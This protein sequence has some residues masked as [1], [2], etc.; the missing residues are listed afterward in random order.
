MAVRITSSSL[1]AGAFVAHNLQ[2]GRLPVGVCAHFDGPEWL[3][4]SNPAEQCLDVS[5][6]A[7]GVT[8]APVYGE[9]N[10][11]TN[12]LLIFNEYKRIHNTYHRVAHNSGVAVGAYGYGFYA[13]KEAESS[14]SAIATTDMP[15]GATANTALIAALYPL[16]NEIMQK[17][18]Q[19][20]RINKVYSTG[21]GASYH[22]AADSFNAFGT[23][24]VLTGASTG[25]QLA[26]RVNLIVEKA[27]DH[28]L[29]ATGGVHS[30][31]DSA[32]A[33]TLAA[34]TPVQSA[35]DF[36]AMLT[37]LTTTKAQ[38]NAHIADGSIHNAADSDNTI[39]T[40]NPSYPSTLIG[41]GTLPRTILTNHAAH[42]S[43]LGAS[44]SPIHLV[45][46]A[47]NALVYTNPTTIA[48]LISAAAELYVKQPGHHRNAVGLALRSV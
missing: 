38:V 14:S 1:P 7:A 4:G 31:A 25:A 19:G 3:E 2:K 40:A 45:Y 41:S 26:E 35:D 8:S 5:L 11:L 27:I 20:H 32:R 23:T 48:T 29:Y 44:G 47:A 36:D 6:I 30:S 12:A 39:T 43:A 28:L 10:A 24:V 37:N 13:H 46:D 9:A 18:D 16:A 42:L 17:L 34:L 22:A 33:A 15:T 21:A